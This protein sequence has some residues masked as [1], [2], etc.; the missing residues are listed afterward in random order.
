MKEILVRLK[1]IKLENNAKKE[2]GVENSK[3]EEERM[4]IRRKE[5]IK[6]RR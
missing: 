6:Q 3:G 4:E 2:S 5:E 1:Q